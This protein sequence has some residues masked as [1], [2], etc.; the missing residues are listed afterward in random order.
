MGYIKLFFSKIKEFVNK[1]YWLQP[2]LL[3]A[4]VFAVVF[5]M[6]GFSNLASS[7]KGWFS[8]GEETCKACTTFTT[9]RYNVFDDAIEA[10]TDEKDPVFILITQKNCSACATLY[11]LLNKFMKTEKNYKIYQLKLDY[12]KDGE[13]VFDSVDSKIKYHNLAHSLLD[14]AANNGENLENSMLNK[15]EYYFATPTLMVYANNSEDYYNNILRYRV[16]SF[17]SSDYT[18]L[19]SFFTKTTD[20]Y[21]DLDY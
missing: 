21:Y 8:K 5:S 4:I 7:I 1:N 6:T 13:L 17:S 20:G 10:A 11:P 14:L 2:V 3:V 18:S 9:S 16:G 15:G 12:D 19:V